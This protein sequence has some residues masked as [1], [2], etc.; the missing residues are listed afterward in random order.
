MGVVGL[1]SEG[2]TEVHIGLAFDKRV[3]VDGGVVHPLQVASERVRLVESR[4]AHPSF[5]ASSAVGTEE[6]PEYYR[7]LNE[8][9]KSNVVIRVG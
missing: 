3:S 2:L 1:F 8:Y 6:A 4:I 7:R 5:I 9:E